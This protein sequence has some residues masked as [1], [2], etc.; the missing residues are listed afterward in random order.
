[1]DYFR[2]ADLFSG[3]GGFSQGFQN[4]GGF[5]IKYAADNNSGAMEIYKL[6]NK[7]ET[8]DLTDLSIQENHN[9]IIQK[10]KHSIDV[11]VGGPPCQGFS[12][13]GKRRDGDYRSTLVDIYADIA[14]KVQPKIIVMENVRGIT[15]KKHPKGGT[16]LDSFYRKIQFSQ[17]KEYKN[18]RVDHK[19]V[20]AL[21]FGM[22][23]TRRRIFTIA[24]R[25]DLV[26]L[27]NELDI[28]WDH[29]NSQKEDISPCL[30]DVIGD[31]E[32][33]P[34]VFD[35]KI[36]TKLNRNNG[37]ISMNHSAILKKRLSFVPID[38]GLINVPKELLNEHLKKMLDGKY[39]SGG[40]IKNIYGRLNWEGKVGTIVAGMDKITCGRFVHPES[41]RLLTPRECAR[42]QSFSDKF[43]LSG[44]QVSR[45]Y[46]IGNA[47]PPKLSNVI[48][49]SIYAFLIS[50]LRIKG[51][52]VKE[53]A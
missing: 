23:Q 31:L 36:D 51:D 53:A 42:L 19:E 1:M 38:G 25:E 22:A 3:C 24:I 28:I 6:N 15:S 43:I 30:K 34:P 45:Y 33:N 9:K 17:N 14:L 4:A 39:G 12:T 41:D 52:I 27:G 18:Y 8:Y 21:D 44:S 40:H 47:V 2:V 11:L 10:L 48:A 29:L 20:L 35:R 32:N 5:S 50:K 49:K 7:A 16:Y 46:S 26:T 13:L 37:H